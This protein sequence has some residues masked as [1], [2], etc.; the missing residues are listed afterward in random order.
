ME[1]S[2]EQADEVLKDI[3]LVAQRARDATVYRTMA[4]IM[5][6]WGAVLATCFSV[7]H[8]APHAA[9][10]AWLIGDGLGLAGTA[11]LGWILPRRGP[12]VSKSANKLG[13][14]VGWF[15]FLLCTFASSWLFILWPW[16]PD[17]LGTFIVSLAMFAYVVLGLWLEMRPM[18]VI[19]L[20]VALLA[21]GAYFASLVVPGYLNLWLAIVGGGALLVSGIYLYLKGRRS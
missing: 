8:F 20:V 19:G 4:P 11:L 7:T 2:R 1:V 17:Q 15:W 16:H 9:G 13:R 10:M 3:E 14:R 5:M 18:I 6:L 12:V 21:T